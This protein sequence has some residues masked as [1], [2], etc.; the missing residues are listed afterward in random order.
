MKFDYESYSGIYLSVP[1]GGRHIDHVVDQLT[2]VLVEEY[3]KKNKKNLAK[4][5]EAKK[6]TT[7]KG[8]N[9]KPEPKKAV[10]IKPFQVRQYS[11]LF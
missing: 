9:K 5:A 11:P 6:T 3:E 8:D 10:G 7:K 1:Q 4:K 2:K